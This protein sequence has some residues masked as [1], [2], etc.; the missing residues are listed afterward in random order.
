MAA[1]TV[2]GVGRSLA[3]PACRAAQIGIYKLRE[4]T[5]G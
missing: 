5:K 4:V 2:G 1:F 3:M